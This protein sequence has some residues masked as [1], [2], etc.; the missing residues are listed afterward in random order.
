MEQLEC[1]SDYSKSCNPMVSDPPAHLIDGACL[2]RAC[3][4]ATLQLKKDPSHGDRT[5]THQLSLYPCTWNVDA[6]YT[7]KILEATDKWAHEV[8]SKVGACDARRK[9]SIRQAHVAVGVWL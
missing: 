2:I 8:W 3:W 6:K 4:Y 9:S 5:W 7:E 1:L